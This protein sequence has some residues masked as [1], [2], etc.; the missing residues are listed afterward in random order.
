MSEM[1]FSWLTEA[2]NSGYPEREYLDVASKV[3][4]LLGQ[5]FY[6]LDFLLPP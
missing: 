3:V 4:R 1:G 5:G 2:L 6:S